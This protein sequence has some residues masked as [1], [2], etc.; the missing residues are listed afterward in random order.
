MLKKSNGNQEVKY[1]IMRKILIIPI[2]LLGLALSFQCKKDKDPDKKDGSINIFSLED[3]KQLGQQVSETIAADT[4]NYPVLDSVL[5][6]TAYEH[7]I[8]IRNTILNSG[9]VKYRDD[10][11]WQCKIIY[12]DSVLN[13]F[14][15]P[16]GYIYVYTG[17]IKYL[18]SEDQLAGVLGHEIAHADRR[19]S[20]DQLTKQYGIVTLLQIVAGKNQG[21]LADVAA[22][23]ITLSF[24]RDN[25]SE[26]DEYSV[27][28][29]YPTEYDARGVAR[30]FEKIGT[31]S[32]PTFLSTHPDPEDRVQKIMDKWTALGAKVGG[33]FDD[34]YLEFKNS[35]P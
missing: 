33:T 14:A 3:D 5:Y 28:Y 29:L 13:A 6:P 31:S 16:G 26:A 21:L 17:L 20:T 4:V 30:F 22:S 35:L 15:T 25:E 23:L 9:K 27:I 8:R 34:R 1:L 7:L 19:H 10:F 32:T 18:D 24:S 12:D 11:K 2:L